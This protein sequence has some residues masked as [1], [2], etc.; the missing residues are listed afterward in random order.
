MVEIESFS[1]AVPCL[2]AVLD[3]EAANT[4]MTSLTDGSATN[5]CR[6]CKPRERARNPP[7][8]RVWLAVADEEKYPNADD[9]VIVQ[10]GRSHARRV[11]CSPISLVRDCRSRAWP[12]WAPTSRCWSTT[13]LRVSAGSD[14]RSLSTEPCF[15]GMILL[16]ELSRRRIRSIPKLIRVGKTE[17]V[18]VLRVDKEKG[19]P[20]LLR[21]QQASLFAEVLWLA[22]YIDLS[23]RRVSPEDIEKAEEKFNKTKAVH[24]I[25][26][27]VSETCKVPLIDLYQ[28]F[29]WDLYRKYGHAYDAF[30]LI[31]RSVITGP[32]ALAPHHWVAP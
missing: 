19:A 8:D 5:N 9:L 30:K 6:M 14:R 21:V 26:R 17:I 27:H 25:L 28:A 3:C 2:L 4:D 29:G 7:A 16:S 11:S 24:S 20:S 1:F 32:F 13:T 18:M 12:K 22:G 15:P 31:V 10:V 23:K